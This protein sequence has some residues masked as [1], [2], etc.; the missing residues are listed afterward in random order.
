MDIVYVVYLDGEILKDKNRK[1]VYMEEKYA[2]QVV[3]T[4]AKDLARTM[5][6]ACLEDISKEERKNWIQ[7]ARDR[8]EI[9][10][11]TKKDGE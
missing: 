3:T 2:K 7:K 5:Y 4:K 8:F 6:G 9:V 10:E 1:R 11:F